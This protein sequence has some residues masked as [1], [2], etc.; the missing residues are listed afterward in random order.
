MARFEAIVEEELG[1]TDGPSEA[2]P[3]D[4]Q[5]GQE[6]AVVQGGEADISE[7]ASALSSEPDEVDDDLEAGESEDSEDDSQE[8]SGETKKPGRWKKLKQKH[9]A[10][11]EKHAKSEADREEIEGHLGFFLEERK[12]L[13]EQINGLKARLGEFVEETPEQKELED[14]RMERQRAAINQSVQERQ[15]AQVQER[16]RAQLVEQ[17][18]AELV[19]AAEKTGLD[20]HLILTEALK[21]NSTP[22][23]AAAAL[24]KRMRQLGQNPAKE[25]ANINARTR[26]GV[27]GAKG[28]GVREPYKPGSIE[29]MEAVAARLGLE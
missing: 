9:A 12:V 10:L 17:T 28:Q 11:Q 19:Q 3:V 18:K 24:L 1:F 13:L 4:A 23:D 5:E 6:E 20:A 25:Q 29:H 27:N 7:E 8:A 15:K 22:T 2:A 16:A 14:L 26:A 21:T